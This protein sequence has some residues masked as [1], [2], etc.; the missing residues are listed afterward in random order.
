MKGCGRLN[1]HR[2]ESCCRRDGVTL[3]DPTLRD[4]TDEKCGV[5]VRHTD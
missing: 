5:S 3:Q 4:P 1:K 2:R